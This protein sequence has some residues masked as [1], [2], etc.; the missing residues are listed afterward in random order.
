MKRRRMFP[1]PLGK[2]PFCN[3]NLRRTE[4]QPSSIQDVLVSAFHWVRAR[5][6][7][8]HSFRFVGRMASGEARVGFTCPR[9]FR[10]SPAAQASC[11]P[12]R[13]CLKL[14]STTHSRMERNMSFVSQHIGTS[15][16]FSFMRFH[17]KLRAR[18]LNFPCPSS[19]EGGG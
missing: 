12:G 16:T 6:P 3:L 1:P 18:V 7:F 9:I 15:P 17:R 10:F 14:K 2:W 13:C 4:N 5:T 19:A 8:H 11:N